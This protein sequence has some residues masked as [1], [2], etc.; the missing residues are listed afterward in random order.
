MAVASIAVSTEAIGFSET[1]LGTFVMLGL[2]VVALFVSLVLAI[3]TYL[4]SRFIY[5]PSPRLGNSLADERYD[6]QEYRNALLRGYS[7][8]VAANRRVVRVNANRFKRCLTVLLVALLYFFGAGMLITLPDD[9]KLDIA[10]FVG[11]T[12]IAGGLAWYIIR[13]GY[14]TIEDIAFHQ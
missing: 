5:G 14:L 7:F 10:V 8:G 3:F 12:L 1:T 11:C 2:G 4:S 9:G 13:E 6:P